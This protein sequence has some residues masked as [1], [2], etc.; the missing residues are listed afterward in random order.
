M[1]S[2]KWAFRIGAAVLAVALV[3]FVLNAVLGLGLFAPASPAPAPPGPEEAPGDPAPAARQALLPEVYLNGP[4]GSE[5]IEIGG[6]RV[7]TGN[8][9]LTFRFAEP[10]DI[11]KEGAVTVESS[12][13]GETD[14]F[15]MGYAGADKTIVWMNIPES[16]L[17][18]ESLKIE[19][20]RD[21]PADGEAF[22]REPV[23][24]YVTRYAPNK[25]DIRQIVSG[26]FPEEHRYW[27][28]E[29]TKVFDLYFERPV[30]PASVERAVLDNLSPQGRQEQTAVSFEW[31][32]ER[33]VRITFE[34]PPEGVWVIDL[35]GAEDRIGLKMQGIPGHENHWAFDIGPRQSLKTYNLETG[36]LETLE[37]GVLDE[38]RYLS[39]RIDGEGLHLHLH[40]DPNRDV[41]GLLYD[42][43]LYDG[44]TGTVKKTEGQGTL[45]TA[46]Q[47]L[48]EE[49]QAFRGVKLSPDGSKAAAFAARIGTAGERGKP[50]L[51]I[52]DTQTGALEKTLDMPFSILSAGDD[53]LPLDLHFTWLS[54]TVLFTEGFA[55]LG[56]TAHIYG[57]NL[58]TDA[59]VL[60][61]ENVREPEYLE[62][63]DLLTAVKL[64]KTG[65]GTIQRDGS[66]PEEIDWYGD[67]EIILMGVYGNVLKYFDPI[68][69][70]GPAANG[71]E[72]L[73]YD[74]PVSRI[75]S[76]DNKLVYPESA[77]G[78][79]RLVVQDLGEAK[80]E[81]VDAGMD[82]LFL[83]VKDGKAYLLEKAE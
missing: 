21:I 45:K 29:G 18:E 52:I 4:A 11:E 77:G 36:V 71:A 69:G 61:K 65:E 53:I 6:T 25:A 74:A 70:Y 3:L 73:A 14:R 62:G 5:R 75:A 10:V 55:E 17:E 7:L 57:I 35:T 24:L 54:E 34:E 41:E 8:V 72:S 38:L 39:G 43:Y 22:L 2:F 56:N 51:M 32:N 83:G 48:L 49:G 31:K 9:S 30:V 63:L 37:T 46:Y 76:W 47:G 66:E 40:E 42:A 13:D 59:V 15:S 60:L 19:L 64:E 78:A 12:L 79:R 33:E 28:T 16:D 58:E 82:F 81:Y 23:V 68:Q 67:S 1:E 27:L 44:T 50:V 20:A 26:R 80:T